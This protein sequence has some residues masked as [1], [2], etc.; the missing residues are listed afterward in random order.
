MTHL[1]FQLGQVGNLHKLGSSV[2][3]PYRLSLVAPEDN[4]HYSLHTMAG[5]L[6]EGT[7]YG[8]RQSR[9][10][11]HQLL[12][13]VAAVVHQGLAPHAALLLL[14]FHESTEKLAK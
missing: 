11:W 13:R 3:V 1:S 9:D 2:L 7:R 8:L 10:C 5:L 14:Q 12:L 4:I 6:Q